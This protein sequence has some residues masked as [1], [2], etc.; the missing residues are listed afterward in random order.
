M[1]VSD[2][3]AAVEAALCAGRL[4]CV[5]VGHRWRRGAMGAGG[6]FEAP[7]DSSVGSDRDE[8]AARPV[9]T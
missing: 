8:L 7:A 1:V 4:V 9:L 5:V 3:S 6:G 2:D